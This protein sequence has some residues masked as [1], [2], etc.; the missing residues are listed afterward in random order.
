MQIQRKVEVCEP[1][2]LVQRFALDT[3]FFCQME[4]V[5]YRKGKGVVL[6]ALL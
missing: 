1:Q 6:H 3:S 4:W 5:I 2:V